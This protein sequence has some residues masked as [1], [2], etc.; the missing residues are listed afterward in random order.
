MDKLMFSDKKKI[1]IE[2][3]HVNGGYQKLQIINPLV[4]I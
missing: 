1:M 4:F 2:T 3:H